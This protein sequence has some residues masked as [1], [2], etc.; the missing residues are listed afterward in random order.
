MTTGLV[1][2]ARLLRTAGYYE[3]T[4]S[5]VP[6]SEPSVPALSHPSEVS[7]HSSRSTRP[8]C[9]AL[10]HVLTIAKVHSSQNHSQRPSQKYIIRETESSTKSLSEKNCSFVNQNQSQKVHHK[11]VVRLSR[12]QKGRDAVGV[13]YSAIERNDW[14]IS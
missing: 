9:A 1:I 12:N 7:G 14:G 2:S 6:V 13:Q 5:S 11:S 4:K 8:C 10:L 3:L